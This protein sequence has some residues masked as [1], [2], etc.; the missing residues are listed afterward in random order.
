M[1]TTRMTAVEVQDVARRLMAAKGDRALIEA[2]RRAAQS[3]EAGKSSA[4]QDWRRV[5]DAIALMR[6][7]R[8][9]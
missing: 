4:A 8:A 6:G 5:A 1:T 3:I 9:T 2:T 7:P